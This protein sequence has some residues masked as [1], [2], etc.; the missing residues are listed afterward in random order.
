MKPLSAALLVLAAA[1]AASPHAPRPPQGVWAPRTYLCLRAE[2]PITV[3]GNLAEW[4]GAAWTEDFVDIRGLE[5][6]PPLRTRAKMLWDDRH[7]YFAAELE[8]PHVWATLTKRDSIIFH[9]NDF[10]VF[11]DPDADTHDYYELEINAFGT[12]WDLFL[13]KPYRDGGPAVHAWDITGLKSAVRVHGTINDPS[14]RDEGWTVEIAI[15]WKAL[16]EEA[17]VR[18]PPRAGDR[19]RVNFSRVEWHT[20]FSRRGYAKKT[21]PG[22]GKPLPEENW[23]WSPQGLVNMHYPERWGIV[24][25]S[26][27]ARLGDAAEVFRQ[28]EDRACEELRRIYYAQKRWFADHARY[29]ERQEG[30]NLVWPYSVT[31]TPDGFDAWIDWPDGRRLLIRED[32]WVGWVEK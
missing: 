9:D 23:V 5:E 19:W 21:N 32:G 4:G 17:G 27:D 30:P 25:F 2:A 28:D 3:D 15:P 18:C 6:A 7:F 10:E 14:D 22:T 8:E 12:E 31:T 20:H 24:E 13:H 1:C 16:E 11:L 29:F 26:A